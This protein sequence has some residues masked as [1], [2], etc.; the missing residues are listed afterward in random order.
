MSFFII[1]NGHPITG[2]QGPRGGAEVELYSFSTSALEGSGWSAPRPGRFTPEKDPVPIVQ[3][4]VWAPGP[5][6]TYAKN[7]APPGFDPRTIQPVV[8]RYTDCA[9]RPT[10]SHNTLSKMHLACTRFHP[11]LKLLSTFSYGITVTAMLIM[12]HKFKIIHSIS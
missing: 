9:T 5:V 10:F 8:S 12:D 7:L 11:R 1:I 2:H 3:V 4:A 6:W